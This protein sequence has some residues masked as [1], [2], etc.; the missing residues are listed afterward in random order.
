MKVALF[1]TPSHPQSIGADQHILIEPLALEYI[2]AGVQDNHDV[3]LVDLRIDRDIKETLATFKPD[4]IGCG[5]CTADV[6][7]VKSIFA[8]AKK[9]LPKI[10]TVVGGHHATVKPQDFFDENIDVVVTGEGVF[11]FKK[12]CEYHEKKRSFQDIENIYYRENGK[13]VSTKKKEYPPLD[14]LPF[15]ARTLTSRYRTYYRMPLATHNNV[16]AT[17]RGSSGCF[18]RCNFCAVSSMFNR[19]IYKRSVDNIIEELEALTEPNIFWVDDEF[20]I[21]PQRAISIA[22][23]ISRAGIKK[24]HYFYGRADNIVRTPA[25]IEEWA[26]NGL[27]MILIG[28]ESHTENELSHMRKD[29]SISKNEEAIRICHANNVQVKGYFIVNPDY[30]RVDFRR[31]AN[32]IREINVDAPGF[33]VLTPFPGTDYYEEVK[34]NLISHKHHL[35]DAAHALVPTKLPLKRFYKEFSRAIGK[36]TSLKRKLDIIKHVNPKMRMRFCKEWLKIN[37]RIKNAYQDYE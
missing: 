21:E 4:I 12:I 35:Y 18:F 7:I 6:P 10:L 33:S 26:K 28:L 24:H 36:S 17:I 8:E 9:V 3:K 13:M 2:G 23:A 15:P 20:I 5:G 37:R 25:C 32:Y 34:E 16:F 29:I 22:K 14:D 19:Q 31:L 1:I 27:K 11:P 30:D